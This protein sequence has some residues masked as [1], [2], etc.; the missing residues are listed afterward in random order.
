RGVELA[1]QTGNR[2][3]SIVLNYILSLAEGGRGNYDQALA[4]L[5]AGK[6][7]ADEIDSPWAA[8]HINQLGWLHA[9][10]GDWETAYAIDLSGL[11]P[12]RALTG[13]K[14][15]EISTQINLALDCIGLGRLDE[16][17]AYIQ[18]C[19]ESLGLTEYGVHDW[20]WRTRLADARARL[21]LSTG[22]LA[23]A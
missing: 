18:A 23:E 22:Q 4:D 10:L 5:E 3:I 14:E 20:R 15:I 2:R 17:L 1:R 13:F 21:H 8:R 7:A 12:T 6:R 16:A 11:E 9:E 19:E